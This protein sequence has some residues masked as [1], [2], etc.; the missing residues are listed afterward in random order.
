MK[1][2]PRIFVSVM[3]DNHPKATPASLQV[4]QRIYD[5]LNTRGFEIEEFFFRG[6][7][8]NVTW[9][10]EEV[11][12]ILRRCQGAIIFGVSKWRFSFDN[13]EEWKCPSDYIHIEGAIAETKNLPTFVIKEAG[14]L[15]EG[16]LYSGAGFRLT[17]IQPDGREVLNNDRTFWD[18]FDNWAKQ[19]QKR[20]HV[21]LGYSGG[22]TS[23]AVAIRDFLEK[24]GVRVID[25]KRDFRTATTI[26]QQ[27]EE[28]ESSCIGGIFLFTR[29]DELVGEPNLAAPRDNVIFEAGY[30]IHA[31]GQEQVLI[32]LEKGAKLPAD[33]GG[34]IYLPLDDRHNIQ[35]I[36]DKIL[37]FINQNL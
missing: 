29:D 36:Q 9:T 6:L 28:A 12:K 23:T 15:D 25:W 13:G 14:V 30:F 17:T 8:T 37:D 35:P 34:T 5:E 33:I 24:Q 21:F 3:Q 26:M 10:I 2:S 11:E 22:A 4:K 1:P 7:V 20:R 18:V 32:I 19:V 27:I 16:I 31:K